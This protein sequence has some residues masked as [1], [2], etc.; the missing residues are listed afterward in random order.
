LPGRKDKAWLLA[1]ALSLPL[2]FLPFSRLFMLPLALL[3]LLGIAVFAKQLSSGRTILNRDDGFRYFN[4]C[5]VLMWGPML[6]SLVDAE[7][8]AMTAKG[9]V[10]YIVYAM[11]GIGLLALL[12]LLPVFRLSYAL[13][14]FVIIF[15]AIDGVFQTLAGF[16]LFGVPLDRPEVVHG[17][18]SSFFTRPNVYGFYMGML[19]LLP[20]YT[21]YL[22][23][24]SQRQHLVWLVV[25]TAGV[26]VGAAR[27]GWLMYGWGLLPYLYLVF[28]KPA[29]H[30]WRVALITVAAAVLMFLAVL[31]VSPGMQE[32]LSRSEGFGQWDYQSVNRASS[33]RLD[34][35]V[36]AIDMGVQHPLNGVGV[37]S[38]E[39]T[40]RPYLPP[41]ATWPDDVDA[42]HPHHAVLEIWSGA[43][44]PGLLG[45]VLVWLALW[46]LWRQASP[47]QRTLALP[48]L[49]PLA[50]LWWPLN[51][52][53]GFYA[54]ELASL[55]LFL[56]AFSVAALTHRKGDIK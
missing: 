41:Q 34:I 47:E 2:A 12:R 48:V 54:S 31:Q 50:V 7:S 16:D 35:W 27:G 14:S 46:R 13:L 44:A 37:N 4:Y 36:A 8:L 39:K 26:L 29:R 5:V 45:F 51:T 52:H 3:A 33:M 49:I 42:S 40:F 55:T 30:P 10:L 18:A 9:T 32:R 1:L 38:F 25:L 17:H 19:A 53:R 24:A 15:W 43:G 11:G 21:L 22:L 23:K 20:L 56:M 28:V 6:L